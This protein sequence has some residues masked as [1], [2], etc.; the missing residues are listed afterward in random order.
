MLM[1]DYDD[2]MNPKDIKW[3]TWAFDIEATTIALINVNVLII[4]SLRLV[5]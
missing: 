3:A 2:G 4:G 1:G 5:P